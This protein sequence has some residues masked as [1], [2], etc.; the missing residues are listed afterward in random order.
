MIIILLDYYFINDKDKNGLNVN[1]KLLNKGN[2]II[3][4]FIDD[5]I[6][7]IKNNIKSNQN[8]K[9]NKNDLNQR[10]PF[11]SKICKLSFDVINNN[12][13]DE[14]L[15]I[16]ILITNSKVESKKYWLITLIIPAIL[17]LIVILIIIRKKIILK[18]TGK[19]YEEKIEKELQVNFDY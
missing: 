19:I 13:K 15:Y 7:N 16:K 10:C 3:R 5:R 6:S 8:I 2:F 9:I 18:K 12:D 4:L 14:D 17:L 11:D 1:L